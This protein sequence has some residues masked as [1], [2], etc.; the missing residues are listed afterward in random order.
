MRIEP[1]FDRDEKIKREMRS[2]EVPKHL[3]KPPR[4]RL[5]IPEKAPGRG[6]VADA[7]QGCFWKLEDALK[8]DPLVQLF[9]GDCFFG[10][11]IKCGA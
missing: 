5:F 7:K 9:E 2:V 4:K 6:M 3:L 10:G 11:T 1:L 8:G